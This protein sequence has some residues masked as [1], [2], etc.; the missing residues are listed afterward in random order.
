MKTQ[1]VVISKGP[2]ARDVADV[3]SRWCSRNGS[4]IF[5]S[6]DLLADTT[7]S[8]ESGCFGPRTTTIMLQRMKSM[9]LILELFRGGRGHSATYVLSSDF[10]RSVMNGESS[11]LDVKVFWWMVEHGVEPTAEEKEQMK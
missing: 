2:K 6:E 7:F 5:R 10:T 1:N 3:V 9:G 4:F 8:E 11:V